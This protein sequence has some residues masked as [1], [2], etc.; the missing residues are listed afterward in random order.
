MAG[1]RVAFTIDS[2]KLG[3]AER[4]LLQ[5]ARWCRDEGWQV[6][7]ITRQ[8]PELDAYPVPLGVQRWVE[9]PLAPLLRWLG[10]FAFPFRVL[11]LRQLLR[12]HG[13]DLAVGVTTLPAVKL[14]LASAGLPLRTLISERNY[15]PAKP[16]A[17]P[18]RWLRRCTYPWADLHWVQTRVTGDW[19]RQHCGV[20]RQQLVPNAVSWPLPDRDPLLEPD[21]WLAPGAPLIL[22]AGT[23]ARQK[24]FDRLMPVFSTLARRDSSLH[25]ALLGLA[26]GLYQGLDQQ[27]WLRQRLGNNSALQQ[28]LLMPGV[29]GSMARW[30]ARATVFVLPSRFEGFPNVLLEA[31]AAGCAC[32]AS[33][34]LTGPADLIRHGE[35][36]LLLP[37]DA[38]FDDW[39]EA[40]S[41][42]LED[43]GRRLWMGERALLVREQYAEQRLRRDCLEAMRRLCHG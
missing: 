17:L 24:G 16:P 13:S 39:V 27:Q 41:G 37:A 8:G 14:L 3:G 31:M 6:V 23:K 4:V 1:I 11:A 5:W 34:C 30:Y 43:P 9:P 38:T 20:R 22:A 28:R 25:L 35:N 7:V 19:L 42:L 36:G 12:R 21:D 15:P 10:W 18:W 32:I 33:D 29:S 40:I 26:P 2:L